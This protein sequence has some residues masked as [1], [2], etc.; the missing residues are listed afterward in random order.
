MLSRARA[1]L[2]VHN[3]FEV[4]KRGRLTQ[5]KTF[6]VICPF[7]NIQ[8]IDEPYLASH[9]QFQ[10]ISCAIWTIL[11]GWTSMPIQQPHQEVGIIIPA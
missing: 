3:K 11:V 8:C 10:T 1:C 6:L 9:A 7:S 5:G 4:V 2:H